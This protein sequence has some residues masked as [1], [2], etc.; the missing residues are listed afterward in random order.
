[1][2]KK[3]KVTRGDGIAKRGRTKG[4]MVKKVAVAPKRRSKKP[5]G[6]KSGGGFKHYL[7][8]DEQYAYGGGELFYD[9][10]K[11]RFNLTP[12]EAKKRLQIESFKLKPYITGSGSKEYKKSIDAHLDRIGLDTSWKSKKVGLEGSYSQA[13]HGDTDR[14]YDVEAEWRP[15]DKTRV[16]GRTDFDKRHGLEAAYKGDDWGASLISDLNKEHGLDVG[17]K[18]DNWET[19]V[20]SDLKDK[21]MLEGI[22]KKNGNIY[23]CSL[24]NN[25]RLQCNASFGLKHGGKVKKAKKSKKVK[26]HC[27]DGIAKRGRTKGRII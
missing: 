3:S 25:G 14:R 24:D 23:K 13:L 18:G 26:K 1:M 10:E 8:G 19:R 27:G 9:Y 11:K 20:Q 22:Y 4:R 7:G 16:T 2:A 12:S 21:S 6:L 17:Y 15:T 5:L